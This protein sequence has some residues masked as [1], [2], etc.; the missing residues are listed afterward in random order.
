MQI[1]A[2]K[3]ICFT[4]DEAP[5]HKTNFHCS[6]RKNRYFCSGF[7]IL[8][9]LYGM[10]K[11]TIKINSLA[12]GAA[13]LQVPF[14]SLLTASLFFAVGGRIYPFLLPLAVGL[15]LLSIYFLTKKSLSEFLSSS[16][17]FLIFFFLSLW[18]SSLFYDY[19]WD[20][21]CYHQETIVALKNGWNP[22]YQRHAPDVNADMAIWVDHYAKGAETISAVIYSATNIIELGKAINFILVFAAGFLF[23]HFLK[24]RF[25]TISTGKKALLAVIFPL[26]PVVINQLFTFYIDGLAYVLLLVLIPQLVLTIKNPS[27]SK[28][29]LIGVTIFLLVSIKFNLIFWTAF[30]LFCYLVHIVVLKQYKLLKR[31]IAVAAV[32]AGLGIL[33]AGYNPYI[34]NFIERGNPFYPFFGEGKKDP[35]AWTTPRC[36]RGKSRVEA[37][38]ISVLSYPNTVDPNVYAFPWNLKKEYIEGA[39][40]YDSRIGGF[41]AFFAWV[42]VLT[43][44]LYAFK[45]DFKNKEKRLFDIFLLLLALALLILPYGWMARYTPFFYAAPLVMLLYLEKEKRNR[46]IILCKNLIYILIIVNF[47]YSLYYSCK[48]ADESKKTVDRTLA[49]LKDCAVPITVNFGWNI[50]FR[51]KADEKA[52]P[53]HETKEEL[54]TR[55]FGPPVYF[56]PEVFEVRNSVL[57]DKTKEK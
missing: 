36:V 16:I 30:T 37:A 51:L 22:I 28:F 17:L 7:V 48:T 45:T 27:K 53:Y 49:V 18:L 10:E 23:Y 34:T 8:M 24:A 33:L 56:D 9:M 21:R 50:S 43:T 46:T 14:F 3:V 29:Y 19:S 2:K 47:S 12:V 40:L 41:G 54:G 15:T 1:Y 35:V 42:L 39:G 5:V 55:I 44:I 26:C 6:S 52:I 32:A 25:E 20:G 31:L 11:F 38:C 13:L 57:F 4:D